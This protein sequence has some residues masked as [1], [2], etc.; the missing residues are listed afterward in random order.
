MN[1][2]ARLLLPLALLAVLGACILPAQRT[3]TRIDRKV[4]RLI[5]DHEVMHRD[6]GELVEASRLQGTGEITLFFPWHATRLHR[7]GR[8]Y[9]RLV[10]W[11]DDLVLASRGREVLLVSVGSA[12]DWGRADWN[13]E[14][15][16]MRAHSPRWVVEEHLVNVPHRWVR[17][18]SAGDLLAP[19]SARGRTWRHVRL[20][21][22]YDEAQLPPLPPG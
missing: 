2:H 22:V 17:F 1:R 15:G 10:A 16:V 8:Q 9:Q 19:P 13:Q 7:G 6:L 18:V 3:V 20:I 21:A 11:L 12:D 5:A 4:D 14:L